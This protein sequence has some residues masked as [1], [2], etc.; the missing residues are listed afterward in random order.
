MASDIGP[1][2][3]FDLNIAKVEQSLPGAEYL[4]M[5]L[6]HFTID[7]PNGTHQ[8]LVLPVFGPCVSPDLWCQL[9]RDPAP[10]L[11]KIALQATQ[12]L[13]FLHENKICHGG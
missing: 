7:G 1:E 5:P 13:A 10:A 3:G 12:A 11:R 6:D 2:K 8:C 4:A 9:G